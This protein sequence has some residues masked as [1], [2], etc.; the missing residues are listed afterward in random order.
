MWLNS[1]SVGLKAV[2]TQVLPSQSIY[3]FGYMEPH[4][5]INAWVLAFGFTGTESFEKP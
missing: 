1:M 3:F 5:T 2:S 4:S